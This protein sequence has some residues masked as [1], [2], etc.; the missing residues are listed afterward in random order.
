[1][2]VIL[3]TFLS[4]GD[5][6]PFLGLGRAL[7]QRGHSVAV[8]TSG[9]YQPDVAEAGLEYIELADAATFNALLD[10]FERAHEDRRG[11]MGMDPQATETFLHLTTEKLYS[12]IEQ[13]HVPGGTVVGTMISGFGAHLAHEKLGVPLACV[14]HNPYWLRLAQPFLPCMPR[15]LADRL[16]NTLLRTTR[17]GRE[18]WARIDGFRGRLGL[19]PMRNASRDLFSS[20]Q[21]NLGLF[22][23]WFAPWFRRD[24]LGNTVLT[25]FVLHERGH[26][27]P[28][29][30]ELSK[31][32]DCGEPPLVF[33][34]ASWRTNLD[35]YFKASVDVCRT[36]SVRGVLL[37]ERA[38]RMPDLDSS[39]IA[40]GYAPLGSLLPRAAAIVH[41]GGIGT[42]AR[43]LAA[44][45]PQLVTPW[46]DDQPHNA[47][48][49]RQLGVGRSVTPRHYARDAASRLA[50]ILESD[51][52]R[53]RCKQ[54][55]A[56]MEHSPNLDPAC[57]RLEQLL[58]E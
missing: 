35:E 33:Y 1:M 29:P 24:Y 5:V 26:A 37:S 57:E 34:N 30:D 2:H 10:E 52:I 54:F 42:V 13:H 21:L 45:A 56:R 19:P 39:V 31:F 22:P 41:H 51:R 43:A 32:L 58:G 28:L 12:L 55:A 27:A 23:S 46:T 38:R 16:R 44:G 15:W 3:A 20:P 18:F 53:G 50:E 36:L 7:R 17:L 6:Y 14:W 49:V 8:I 4:K 40:V 9:Q 25:D 11:I 47:S 48:L